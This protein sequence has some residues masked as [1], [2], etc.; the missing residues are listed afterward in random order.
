MTAPPTSSTSPPTSSTTT[1]L[2]QPPGTQA[3][4]AGFA[5]QTD[6]TERFWTY[7]GNYCSFGTSCRPENIPSGVVNF[8]G[9]HDTSC[10]APTTQ[11]TVSIT[12]HANLFWWCAPGGADTGHVMVGLATSGYAITG[13]TPRQAFTNV[14]SICW[15]QNLTDLGG[16]KWFTVT[17]VPASVFTSHPNT[18]PRAAQEGEGPYRLDYTLPEFDT[19]NAPGDFNLQRQPRF[20]FKLFRNELRLFN[21]L[22]SFSAGGASDWGAGNGFIAGNDKATRYRHCLTENASG[23]IVLTQASQ[24]WQTGARFPDGP[25]YVIFADDTYDSEKHGPTAHKTWHVDSISIEVGGG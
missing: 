6:F 19:D 2:P 4:V 14:R 18:N 15:D 7:T 5:T 20:M 25:V 13:F 22:G 3:F 1:T 21:R 17:L 10:A 8:S 24:T 23:L 9:D 16:G 11:R 12:N